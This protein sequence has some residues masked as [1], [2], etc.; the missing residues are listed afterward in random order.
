MS[1]AMEPAFGATE[2]EGTCC[3]SLFIS[4]K[5]LIVIPFYCYYVFQMGGGYFS[6]WPGYVGLVT[7][8]CW[9]VILTPNF[10]V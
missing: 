10:R 9:E 4:K 7:S 6:I 2:K 3:S 1:E 8:D 5:N